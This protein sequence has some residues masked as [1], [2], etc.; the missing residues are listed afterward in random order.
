MIIQNLQFPKE[1]EAE[2]EIYFRSAP[3][4]MIFNDYFVFNEREHISFTTY[5]NAFSFK[6]WRKYTVID[7]VYL[8]LAL[9]DE[10]EITLIGI[11]NTERGVFEIIL[12]QE[13]I[14]SKEKK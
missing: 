12:N 13:K 7:T 9:K 8:S 5:F 6:K 11:E 14:E 3:P 10:F 4:D 2:R 1:N